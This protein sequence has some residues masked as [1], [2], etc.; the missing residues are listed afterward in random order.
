MA[1]HRTGGLLGWCCS[2]FLP[3]SDE[4]PIVSKAPLN[5]SSHCRP[6]WEDYQCVLE[7]QEIWVSI[8]SVSSDGLLCT[9]NKQT[10]L[11]GVAVC[12]LAIQADMSCVSHDG[13]PASMLRTSRLA[14]L[15]VYLLR[16]YHRLLPWV[17]MSTSICCLAFLPVTL[18]LNVPSG[19]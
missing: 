15:A 19:L 2:S 10:P 11:T 4:G 7:W 13:K 16:L 1:P 6:Q 17:H 18:W 9:C 14:D 5:V 8:C 3:F 12:T